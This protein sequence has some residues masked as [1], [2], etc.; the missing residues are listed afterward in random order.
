MLTYGNDLQL[1]LS[2]LLICMP[3]R[4]VQSQ[5][6]VNTCTK[7]TH[8]AFVT[9]LINHSSQEPWFVSAHHWGGAKFIG[10]CDVKWLT[11][12]CKSPLSPLCVALISLIAL[13]SWEFYCLSDQSLNSHILL[14]L[15]FKEFNH[16]WRVFEFCLW[17]CIILIGKFSIL[18]SCWWYWILTL[19]VLWLGL[20]LVHSDCDWLFLRGMTE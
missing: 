17:F 13:N 18:V 6:Y 20:L 2:K 9:N 7:L 8:I 19:Y 11:I 16:T 3:G 4:Q 1:L 10:Q 15:V 14:F 12:L 5:L